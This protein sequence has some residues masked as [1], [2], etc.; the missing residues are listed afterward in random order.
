MRTLVFDSE[1]K[2]VAVGWSRGPRGERS[3]ARLR[4]TENDRIM[5]LWR[6]RLLDNCIVH[7]PRRDEA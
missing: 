3:P 2:I 1:N 7:L 6:R 5:F 4:V